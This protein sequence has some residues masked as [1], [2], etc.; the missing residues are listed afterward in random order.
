M[1]APQLRKTAV[2]R[3][4]GAQTFAPAA[5]ARL[6]EAISGTQETDQRTYLLVDTPVVVDAILDEALRSGRLLDVSATVIG[7]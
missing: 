1:H 6:F 4:S 7:L 2:L 3:L 5:T